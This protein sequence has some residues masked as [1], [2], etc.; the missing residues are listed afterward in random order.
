[1]FKRLIALLASL[2][3]PS[4][5]PVIDVQREFTAKEE[6]LLQSLDEL[7]RLL[8]RYGE[9]GWARHFENA[10]QDLRAA[11]ASGATPEEK[12]ALGHNLRS[13]FGGMGSFN[14]LVIHPANGH[15][16]AEADLSPVNERIYS[17]GNRIYELSYI[18][19]EVR[20]R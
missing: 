19:Q 11:I 4:R 20:Y 6:E 17:L 15:K 13:V 9:R 14:D 8:T 18:F 10:A 2:L 5:D 1:M 3:P 12:A 16:I 7:V